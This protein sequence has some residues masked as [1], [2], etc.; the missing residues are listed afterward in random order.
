VPSGFPKGRPIAVQ[1]LLLQYRKVEFSFSC[2]RTLWLSSRRVSPHLCGGGSLDVVYKCGVDLR[3][4][5]GVVGS[6]AGYGWRE[7]NR[8]VG[9][10]TRI[11]FLDIP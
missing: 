7:L 1:F 3:A 9:M 5:A 11:L 8:S 2:K 6:T 10:L 4:S